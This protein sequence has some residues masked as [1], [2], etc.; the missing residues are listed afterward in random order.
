MSAVRVRLA[1][2]LALRPELREDESVD[3]K[4]DL[5]SGLEM[6]TLPVFACGLDFPFASEFPFLKYSIFRFI[7]YIRSLIYVTLDP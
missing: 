7:I 5:L 3:T 2:E 1:V 6:V 4:N